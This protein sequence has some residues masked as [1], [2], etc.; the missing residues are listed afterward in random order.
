MQMK[1][2]VLPVLAGMLLLTFTIIACQKETASPADPG[3]ASAERARNANSLVFPVNSHPYGMSYADWTKLWWQ[4]MVEY[5][6][7]NNPW[8]NPDNALFYESGQVYFLAGI[9]T[10]GGSVDI[11]VPTGKAILF[12]LVNFYNTS[13]CPFPGY[14]PAPGQTMEQFLTQITADALALVDNLSATVDGVAIGNLGSYSFLT[15]MFQITVN[16]DLADCGFD[17][18]ATGESQPSVAGGYYLMLKPMAPGT[19]T[20][21]YHAEIPAWGAVQDGTYHITVQ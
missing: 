10:P 5:D 21:H 18:C 20:V 3:N 7:A 6:C 9:S 4:E 2:L 8:L 14:G 15:N 1:K 16:P 19:H 17:P 12:P 13:P 11:T